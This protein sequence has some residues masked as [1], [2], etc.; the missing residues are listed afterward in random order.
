MNTC[1]YSAKQ[2]AFYAIALREDYRATGSWPED[3]REISDELYRSLLQGQADGK[4]IAPDKKGKPVL[5][6]PPAPDAALLIARAEA[7]KKRLMQLA[8]DNIA[9]LQDAEA[10]EM[11]T[12]DEKARLLSWRAYRVLLNRVDTARPE[13]PELPDVA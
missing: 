9:T 8:G 4:I 13:W 10:L 2:N 1:A 7:E 3:A 12:D 6:E 5:C 11:A